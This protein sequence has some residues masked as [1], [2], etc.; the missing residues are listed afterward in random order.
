MGRGPQEHHHQIPWTWSKVCRI[1]DGGGWK[2]H[3]GRMGS[4]G[5]EKLGSDR[6]RY[7]TTAASCQ[8]PPGRV[9]PEPI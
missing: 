8:Q 7:L 4:T 1:H 3:G 9:D 5:A 6:L 2:A